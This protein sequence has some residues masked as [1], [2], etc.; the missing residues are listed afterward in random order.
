MAPATLYEVNGPRG[1][2]YA[3][4]NHQTGKVWTE[5]TELAAQEQAS[6]EGLCI[7]EGQS[8][9]H[10]QL[11]ELMI[12]HAAQQLSWAKSNEKLPEK[13]SEEHG[14]RPGLGFVSRLWGRRRRDNQPGQTLS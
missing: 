5:R 10:S 11:L 6:E 13:S 2:Y 1:V 4:R 8:I 7:V 9:D 14:R 12:S 3:V